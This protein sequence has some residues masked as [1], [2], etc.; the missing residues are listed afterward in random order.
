MRNARRR[1]LGALE[2]SGGP[3]RRETVIEKFV[4]TPSLTRSVEWLLGLNP[5]TQFDGAAPI[6]SDLFRAG[7]APA[8]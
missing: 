3:A 7:A 6:I 2:S 5:L 4:S 8:P 1:R